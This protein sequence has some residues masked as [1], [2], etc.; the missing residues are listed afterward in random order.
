MNKAHK[1]ITGIWGYPDP[2]ILEKI[3]REYP[4]N[5][6]IDLDINYNNPS[7]GIL[8]DAYCKIMKNI[9]DN[10]VEMKDDIELIIASVGREKC[11]SGWF[12]AKILEEMGFNVI[13]TKC[14]NYGNKRADTLISTSNLPLK[15]KITAVMDNLIEKQEISL[16]P[17]KPEFGFW[18]V[19]PNDLDF[20]DIFPDSTHVYGWVRAVEAQRPADLDLEMFVDEDVPTVFFAQTFC[21]KMQLAKYLAKKYGGIY[22][23]VDDIAS[24]SVKAKIEAFIK[25][26]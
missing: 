23:D 20:L 5:L 24:N 21:A 7:S 11:D 12:A 1:K 15:K 14:E 9:V 26:G 8:P 6:I 22:I 3:K 25:L 10:A 2:D 13:R 19:P 16:E 17:V 4:E 18:G